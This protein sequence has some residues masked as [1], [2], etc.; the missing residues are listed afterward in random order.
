MIQNFS[1]GGTLQDLPGIVGLIKFSLRK[2][3]PDIVSGPWI[4]CTAI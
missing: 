1:L 3:A 4:V 2:A